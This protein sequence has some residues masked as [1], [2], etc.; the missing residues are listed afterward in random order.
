MNESKFGL[1]D[2]Y[3]SRPNKNELERQRKKYIFEE[4][5]SFFGKGDDV[6]SARLY[7]EDFKNISD[8]IKEKLREGHGINENSSEIDK[9]TFEKEYPREVIV[10]VL[11]AYYNEVSQVENCEKISIQEISA[12]YLDRKN[13]DA[14]DKLGKILKEKIEERE[15]LQLVNYIFRLPV[16]VIALEKFQDASDIKGKLIVLGVTAAVGKLLSYVDKKNKDETEKLK[17]ALEE[18][19]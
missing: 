11:N 12:K 14:V 3:A 2:A 17:S 7:Q 5:K 16:F 9:A 18:I 15:A 13:L 10:D 1:S 19:V 8:I 6:M 4:I